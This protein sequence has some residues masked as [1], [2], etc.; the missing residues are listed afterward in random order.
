LSGVSR[1][2]GGQGDHLAG[3][4]PEAKGIIERSHDYLE[5]SFLPGRTFASP[6]DFN[7]QL[8]AR[9]AIVNTHPGRALGLRP[10]RSHRGGRGRDAGAAAMSATEPQQILFNGAGMRGRQ[11]TAATS[12]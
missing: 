6:A 10:G 7:D 5:R 4:R 11:R 12:H 8:A 9:L 3:C 1:G 2:V